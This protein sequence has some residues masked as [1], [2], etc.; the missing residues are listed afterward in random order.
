MEFYNS[1]NMKYLNTF[2]FVACLLLSGCSLNGEITTFNYSFNDG[3]SSNCIHEHDYVYSF[4]P[5]KEDSVSIS[6]YTCS[7]GEQTITYGKWCPLSTIRHV[8]TLLWDE[9]VEISYDATV[10]LVMARSYDTTD[11]IGVLNEMKQYVPNEY[12]EI[13]SPEYYISSASNYFTTYYLYEDNVY[14]SFTTFIE[15]DEIT[16]QSWVGLKIETFIN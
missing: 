10:Y 12:K 13:R 4:T 1:N 2:L 16:N 3:V 9:E 14:L 6:S 11:K 5:A 7:C 15:S 8:S